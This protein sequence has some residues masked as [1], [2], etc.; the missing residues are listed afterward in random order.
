LERVAQPDVAE[1][2][3]LHHLVVATPRAEAVE[4]EA[5]DPLLDQITAGGAVDRDGA[6]R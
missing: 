3:S 5:I 1:R 2:A 4:V 6:G